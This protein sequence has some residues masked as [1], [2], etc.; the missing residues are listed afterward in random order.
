MLTAVALASGAAAGALATAPANATGIAGPC[1][2]THQETQANLGFS[3][4]AAVAPVNVTISLAGNTIDS[5]HG[6][7]AVLDFGDGQ[8]VDL[9]NNNSVTHLYQNPGDYRVT[10]TMH[11]PGFTPA[12]E[13]G[14]FLSEGAAGKAL[15]GRISGQDRLDTAVQISKKQWLNTDPNNSWGQAQAAVIATSTN[16]PDALAGVPLAAYRKGPLLLTDPNAGLYGPA[17]AEINRVV[18]KGHTVYILG[19]FAAVPAAV[20]AQLVKEGYKVQRF[21]GHDR[22]DTALQIAK[23]GMGDPKTVVVATGRLFP[24]ALSAGPLAAGP[25]ATEEAGQEPRPA[26]IILTDGAGFYDPASAAYVQSK[27]G[28]ADC[29]A[30]TAVGGAAVKAVDVLAAGKCHSD[31]SGNDRWATSS[32][33]MEQFPRGYLI[34]VA[35][36][37]T[38]ADALAGGAFVANLQQ[39]LLLTDPASLPDTIGPWFNGLAKYDGVAYV[40]VF[41]GPKAVSDHVG[42]QITD[43][44]HSGH[45]TSNGASV[46]N[47]VAG[48]VT[49]RIAGRVAGQ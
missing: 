20:D 23:D 2:S 4:A 49:G 42:A 22:F 24:D 45:Y 25:R 17:D 43:A 5:A 39:P 18:P 7:T 47:S 12:I 32:K 3:P 33:I 9:A 40:D 16:F 38:F 1:S 15:V 29:Q 34:G 13:S 26:A 11:W 14:H 6:C 28:T 31:L 21:A 44:A 27:L 48:Q 30:V 19:G 8:H 36:G 10:L 46:L 35:S 37:T 41:G